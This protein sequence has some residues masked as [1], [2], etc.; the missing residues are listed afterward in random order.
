MAARQGQRLAAQVAATHGLVLERKILAEQARRER[1]RPEVAHQGGHGI[2]D[3]LSRQVVAGAIAEAEGARQGLGRGGAGVVGAPLDGI[4]EHGGFEGLAQ[5]RRLGAAQQPGGEQFALDALKGEQRLAVGE[6]QRRPHL[7]DGEVVAYQ[8]PQR[9]RSLVVRR[10]RLV[11]EPRHA[12]D[13]RRKGAAAPGPVGVHRP[14]VELHAGL[15]DHGGDALPGLLQTGG[16]KRL[17][18]PCHEAQHIFGPCGR[19][20]PRAGRLSAGHGH[21][22]A[23]HVDGTRRIRCHAPVLLLSRGTQLDRAP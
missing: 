18:G 22:C 5:A 17:S 9:G 10:V 23:D 15:D 1:P 20:A 2:A 16:V 12:V 6:R 7:E 3:R 14:L 11:D 8:S 21:L 19:R 4:G 13:K